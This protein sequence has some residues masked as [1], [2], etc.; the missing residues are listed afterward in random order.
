ME[1]VPPEIL[2]PIGRELCVTHRVLD[3]LVPHPRLDGPGIVTNVRQ[4]VVA[5]V[6]QHVGGG[7][8]KAIPT[9]SP[10]LRRAALLLEM[11]LLYAASHHPLA[12]RTAPCGGLTD[13]AGGLGPAMHRPISLWP[14]GQP[15]AFAFTA[16]KRIA[17]AKSASVLMVFLFMAC[18]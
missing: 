2:E 15:C 6:A 16:P 8:G 10:R 17:P 18:S 14:L 9:L 5:A 3:V 1:L 11:Q 12:A 4:R 13:P 7:S